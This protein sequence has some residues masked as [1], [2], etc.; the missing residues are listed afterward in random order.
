MKI[1]ITFFTQ[2]DPEYGVYLTY[3]SLG[4]LK[5]TG[6]TPDEAI[7]DHLNRFTFQAATSK[8]EQ[9]LTQQPGVTVKK[10]TFQGTSLWPI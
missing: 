3:S 1:E 6:N 2:K 9:N 5:G 10:I 4:I 8:Y 7:Q